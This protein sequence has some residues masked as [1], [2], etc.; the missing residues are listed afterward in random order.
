MNSLE[1][2]EM[3]LTIKEKMTMKLVSSASV[4]AIFTIF[5]S[6][7]FTSRAICIDF[8]AIAIKISVFNK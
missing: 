7:F 5:C 8:A 6:D 2:L 1:E 4:V 3:Q